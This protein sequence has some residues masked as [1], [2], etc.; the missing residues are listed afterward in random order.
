MVFLKI[1]CATRAFAEREQLPSAGYSD[2][3]KE[4]KMHVKRLDYFT[5]TQIGED[6]AMAERS[7]TKA[8]C[9]RR[10]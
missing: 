1:H 9:H 4:M 8:R 2:E 7:L 6:Q 5:A 3:I 10:T